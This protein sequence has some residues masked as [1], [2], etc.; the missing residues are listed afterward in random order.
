[1]WPRLVRKEG[2]VTAVEGE[3]LRIRLLFGRFLERA[4]LVTNLQVREALRLKDDLN[5]TLLETA[6]VEEKLS[7]DQ[8]E[9][10]RNHQRENGVLVEK[11]LVE[12]EFVD[13]EA[14][15]A[16]KESTRKKRMPIGRVLVM[17]GSI[18]EEQLEEQIEKFHD[19]N[20]EL[21]AKQMN[22]RRANA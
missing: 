1:M 13:E 16:L 6:L 5:P 3:D 15:E 20:A 4:G 21:K 18:T 10:V 14:V 11:A 17:L 2:W 9:Q 7:V 12:L 22:D 19:Y 8:I